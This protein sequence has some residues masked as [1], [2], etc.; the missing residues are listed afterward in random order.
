VALREWIEIMEALENDPMVLDDRIDWV[1][2]YRLLDR[3]CARHNVG[4]DSM[5]AQA[6]DLQYHD[7]DQTR[8]IFHKLTSGG[9]VRRLIEDDDASRAT[10]WA[11]TTTRAHLRGEFIRR[12]K[13]ASRD[14][15]VDWVHLKLN[16]Q[17]QRTVVCKDPF[18]NVD[19]R[20]QRLID[21]L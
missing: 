15:T 16:E 18:L 3:Y 17:V 5:Q 12:A 7:I 21:S 1:I 6:L 10:E 9:H 19:D 2:K 14:F 4:L 20:V 8:G 13:A 11:P